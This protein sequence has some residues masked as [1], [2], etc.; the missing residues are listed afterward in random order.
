MKLNKSVLKAIFL[1]WILVVFFFYA[2]LYILPKIIDL[3][4]K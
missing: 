2:K 1:A 3:L 4:R